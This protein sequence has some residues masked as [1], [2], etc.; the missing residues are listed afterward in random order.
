M[1]AALATSGLAGNIRA[2]IEG[3]LIALQGDSTE[4]YKGPGL[5]HSKYIVLYFSAG[6]CGPCHLFTPQLSDYYKQLK[7]KYP[8]FEVVFVS[9]DYSEAA[10]KK[11]MAET[12]MPWPA[13]SYAVA[14]SNEALNK[15]CGPGIPDLVLLNE[16]GQVVSDSFVRGEYVGPVK[17]LKDLL[18]LLDGTGEVVSDE[19]PTPTPATPAPEKATH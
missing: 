3:K 17:V 16:N 15:L 11:Y 19:T 14:R 2:D 9:R 6:W 1:V 13:V 5:A 10:M 7:A 18:M 8:G 4:P 12:S